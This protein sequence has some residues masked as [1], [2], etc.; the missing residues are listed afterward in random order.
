MDFL[1]ALEKIRTPF[2][3]VIFQSFTY[4]GEELITLAAILII[5]WCADK[6]FGRYMLFVGVVGIMANTLLKCIYRIPRPWLIDPNFTI[7]ESAREA[8]TG[9]SFPSGHTAN[10]AVLFWSIAL[11]VKNKALKV[12]FLIIP[13][14]VAFSRMYLGVHTPLDVGVSLGI[15]AVLVF[16]GY[17]L[18][19][20]MNNRTSHCFIGGLISTVLA[21]VCVIIIS[22]LYYN[23]YPDDVLIKSGLTDAYKVLG[24][25]AALPIVCILDD[26]YIDYTTKGK[27]RFQLLKLVIGTGVVVAVKELLKIP[28]NIILPENP[29]TG[30]IRYLI[31]A[32]LGGVLIPWLFTYVVKKNDIK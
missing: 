13:F 28:L 17:Y 1:Y 8:A 6:Y 30:F 25:A 9:Y 7:V 22:S 29:V 26:K 32:V 3:D 4:L 10:A 31:I 2:L 11:M 18:Y 23:K 27:W 5:L 24:L 20:K 12:I 14:F 16:G 15:S 21:V 19:K